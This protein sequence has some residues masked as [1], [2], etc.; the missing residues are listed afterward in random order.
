[1]VATTVRQLERQWGRIQ[2]EMVMRTST[3]VGRPRDKFWWPVL[4]M[5]TICPGHRLAFL[6]PA[7]V[8]LGDQTIYLGG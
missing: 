4:G 1:M 7:K 3:S 5:R 8:F 6:R 2:A